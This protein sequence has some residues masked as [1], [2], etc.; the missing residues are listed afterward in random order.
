MASKQHQEKGESNRIEW[1]QQLYREWK[2]KDNQEYVYEMFD[3]FN[4]DDCEID[5]K[6]SIVR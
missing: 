3:Y 2:E 4:E 6:E 5:F 1:F